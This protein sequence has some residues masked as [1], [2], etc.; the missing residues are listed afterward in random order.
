M[1]LGFGIYHILTYHTTWS[2]IGI[3]VYT[4]KIPVKLSH[5]PPP[6]AT[7]HR[8]RPPPTPTDIAHH[9]RLIIVDSGSSLRTG[10]FRG[11]LLWECPRPLNSQRNKNSQR[12]GKPSPQARCH[13]STA[14][15][16]ETAHYPPSPSTTIS[17]H[18]HTQQIRYT[19]H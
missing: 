10:T 3:L 13:T 2:E 18:H 15:T 6:T 4:T 11:F 1:R 12:E 7:A 14:E 9:H 17:H 8:H 19:F 16:A 5:W